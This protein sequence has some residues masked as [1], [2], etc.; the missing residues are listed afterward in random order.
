MK[1]QVIACVDGSRISTAVC[2]S[3]VWASQV[4]AAPVKFLHVLEKNQT[5]SQNDLSGSIGLGSREHLLTEFTKLDEQRSRLA[6][7]HGKHILEDAKSRAQEKGIA[8]VLTEQRHDQ[9]VNALLEAE[10]NAMLFVIGRQGSDHES[11]V[12]SIGS[13]VE[14]VVRSIATPVLMATGRF[15]KPSNYMLAYDGSET[16]E[17]AINRIAKSPLLKQ[18][19]GHLVMVGNDSADNNNKLNA[20]NQVLQDQGH[21]VTA[22]LLPNDNVVDALTQ[23]QAQHNIEFKV[24]GAY[25]HSRIREFFVGSN[26]TKMIAT[27]TVPILILR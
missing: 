10:P 11:Q 2:D 7:E 13:H 26:T 20:A 3:A 1:K 23:F 25:G 18:L 6:I 22:H 17:T 15:S 16:A 27:S 9:L 24:M 4:L 5:Q 12:E 14:N 21:N 8:D 19:P